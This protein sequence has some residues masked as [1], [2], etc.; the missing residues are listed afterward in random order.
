MPGLKGLGWPDPMTR[1]VAGSY[2]ANFAGASFIFVYLEFIAPFPPQWRRG[3]TVLTAGLAVA[4]LLVTAVIQNELIKR[5][6][7]RATAWIY[8]HRPPTAAEQQATLTLPWRS[9][10]FSII[11]WA[12]GAV[13]F[14]AWAWILHSSWLFACQVAVTIALG[15]LVSIA[16]AYFLTERA[17]APLVPVT[18]R[19]EAPPRPHS[20]GIRPRLLL[21]WGL[22]SALPLLGLA[23]LPLDARASAVGRADPPSIAG[24]VIAVSLAGVVTGLV[25]TLAVARSVADPLDHVRAGLRRVEE[26]DLDVVMNVEDG[27]EIGMLQSGFNQMVDGLRERAQLQDLFGRHVGVEVAQ[28]A[29]AEGSGLGG[30]QHTVSVLFVDLVGSTALAEVLPPGEVVATLNAFFDTV[31]RVVLDEGGWVNKFEGDG[32][33]CIFGAPRFHPDHAARALRAAIRLDRAVRDLA[34]EHHG[35]SAGIGVASGLVVAGNVGTEQR[36]EYTVVGRAV[37]EAA[38][39]SEIAKGRPSRVL[40][41]AAA[42][43]DSGGEARSWASL[44]A[45]ALRG[46]SYPVGIYEPAPP[47]VASRAD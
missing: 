42:V 37:N 6:F 43:T 10:I 12:T 13:T 19:S 7:N 38:R 46:S 32:A 17:A 24:A 44:G 14:G 40:A 5:R 9:T 15:G 30:E 3:E 1:M 39:L 22:G 28:R 20:L 23:L 41:A 33:L 31:V 35:V 45:V 4:L 36:Y 21:A 8:E 2:A 11:S 25:M 18:L 27:G 26:G 47:P 34:P 29:L 16:I